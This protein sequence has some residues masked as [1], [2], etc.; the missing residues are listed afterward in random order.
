MQPAAAEM[1]TPK[2]LAAAVAAATASSPM[3]GAASELAQLR[4]QNA[5]LRALLS[6]FATGAHVG[7]AARA[8]TISSSG[9]TAAAALPHASPVRAPS[10]A[11]G[12]PPA[13][14]GTHA[15]AV[16]AA[17]T[18]VVADG[19]VVVTASPSRA[20]SRACIPESPSNA[21]QQWQQQRQQQL[22]AD[23]VEEAALRCA[24]LSHY[25]GLAAALGVCAT[26]AAERAEY[27]CAFAPTAAAAADVARRAAAAA[28]AGAGA[29]TGTGGRAVGSVGAAVGAAAA[30]AAAGGHTAG[31]SG[32]T[33][34]SGCAPP[35]VGGAVPAGSGCGVIGAGCVDAA[36]LVEL[37]RAMRQMCE[38]GVDAEVRASLACA[39]GASADTMSGLGLVDVVAGAAAGAGGV[40]L[41]GIGASCGL[42][43]AAPV[44]AWP[45][46]ALLL[47]GMSG[48]AWRLAEAEASDAC[49]RRAWLLLLWA[50]ALAA[51]LEPGLAR[52]R[53]AHW[54]RRMDAPPSAAT[55]AELDDGA[56][57]VCLLGLEQQ[58]WRARG[59]QPR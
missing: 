51:G 28:L 13:H 27:W 57:E 53:T 30:A 54:A 39:R 50:R 26:I 15:A 36:D 38:L 34:D 8:G 58:L 14:S 2:R 19:A 11:L 5:S 41:S 45:G 56:R 29:G 4:S 9:T 7:K 3:Q 6:V 21:P 16:A 42:Q 24:L 17:E 44:A 20:P 55:L 10:A 43:P 31:G 12:G 49:L 35:Y 48:G 22:S 40:G 46:G 1:D 37:E 47:G 32:V 52:T 25:W 23:E 18:A 33:A 59:L